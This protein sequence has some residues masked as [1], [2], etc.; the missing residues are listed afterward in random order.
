MRAVQRKWVK[1]NQD[2]R[3]GRMMR[4]AMTRN[5]VLKGAMR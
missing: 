1:T 3:T 2:W 5:E 4:S